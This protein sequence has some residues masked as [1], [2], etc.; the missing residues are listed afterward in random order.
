M[1]FW[2]LPTPRIHEGQPTECDSDPDD[3]AG[4]VCQ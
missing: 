2:R 3:V 4:F 1:Y